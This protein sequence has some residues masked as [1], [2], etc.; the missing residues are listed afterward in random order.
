MKTQ[1]PQFSS[2]LQVQHSKQFTAIGHQLMATK[3]LL[4][5]LR[6]AAYNISTHFTEMFTVI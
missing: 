4:Q 3:I 6:L 2:N 1:I 5:I